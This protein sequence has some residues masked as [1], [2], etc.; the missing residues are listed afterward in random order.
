MKWAVAVAAALL[1]DLLAVDWCVPGVELHLA[2]SWLG[3]AGDSTWQFPLWGWLV[4]T[5]GKDVRLL[6]LLSANAGFLCLVLL[7]AT[8][9]KLVQLAVTSP[10]QAGKDEPAVVG[11]AAFI[12]VATCVLSAFAFA[13][14]PGFLRAATRIS[15]VMV[16][17]V[18][19][20]AAL[21]LA[22]HVLSAPGGG[23][24][25]RLKRHWC[26]TV[27]AMALAAYATLEVCLAPQ[28]LLTLVLPSLAT[29][30]AVGAIPMLVIL[31]RI[32]RRRLVH[33]R[34]LSLTYGGWALFL[35]AMAVVSVMTFEYG[36]TAH[37]VLSRIAFAARDF[38][39]VEAD[40]Q[41]A[42]ALV[43]VLRGGARVVDAAA[44][45][46][47]V[48]GS[49]L[50]VLTP[51]RYF[52]TPAAWRET[53]NLLVEVPA[54]DPQGGFVRRLLAQ[55][56][57]GLGCELLAEG[58]KVGA[59]EVFWTI[60][61][62]I[63]RNNYSALV[64][65]TEMARRG[66]AVPQAWLD[67]VRVRRE[68]AEA[69]M[70]SR[71]DRQEAMRIG[72][73]VCSESTPPVRS[74]T[75]VLK[76]DADCAPAGTWMT[77]VLPAGVLLWTFPALIFVLATLWR[78]GTVAF[79]SRPQQEPHRHFATDKDYWESLGVSTGVAGTKPLAESPRR[80]PAVTVRPATVRTKTEPRPDAHGVS[81][82]DERGRRRREHELLS[83]AAFVAGHFVEAYFWA[84]KAK[85]E[86]AQ[87]M[88]RTMAKCCSAWVRDGRHG[89]REN[90]TERF[91][92]SRG[93][94]ARAALR[95]QCGMDVHASRKRIEALAKDGLREAKQY[96]GGLER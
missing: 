34:S 35:G 58:D 5:V 79:A 17:L 70:K 57:N 2:A 15:P 30:L 74:E 63:D 12:S 94:F 55:S 64:N 18:P 96:L 43:F 56:G 78:K 16:S 20:L 3:L 83:E 8:V 84:F 33:F 7:L 87:A 92:A 67:V 19:P 11:H 42:D 77:A 73:P 23:V 82:S 88:T 49:E 81:A 66:E 14:T 13:L 90:V 51:A 46:E 37:G 28:L 76:G 32:R 24:L 72:G 60:S 71:D 29:Y 68:S 65:L 91:T 1:F 62:M 45:R 59:S 31:R 44:V 6:G 26:A 10:R 9:S 69:R 54:D 52:P 95:I 27:S 38:Q 80:N 36:R 4:R 25:D 50:K 93:S 47:S 86:G 61:D 21:A 85:T 22:I 75:V 53:C 48:N 40:G 89:E 39:A 41:V